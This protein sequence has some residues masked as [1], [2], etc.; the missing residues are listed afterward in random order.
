[1]TNTTTYPKVEDFISDETKQKLNATSESIKSYEEYERTTWF[2][3]L[4]GT[5]IG[6]VLGILIQFIFIKKWNWSAHKKIT[7]L[8][9]TSAN[10]KKQYKK[11]CIF[12]NICNA[13]SC[14]Y[15]AYKFITCSHNK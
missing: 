12:A 4:V 11:Y 3:T 2:N 14:S 10:S 13:I 1:M 9:M 15:A 8:L 7:N 6:S 5:A